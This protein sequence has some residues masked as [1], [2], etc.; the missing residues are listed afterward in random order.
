M[1]F[2]IIPLQKIHWPGIK[3][4]YQQGI[5]TKN[6]TFETE[7]PDWDIWDKKFLKICRFVAYDD[8]A[9]GWATL[10]ATST[11]AVYKGVAEV[12]VYV[13][14]NARGKSVG[15]QLLEKLISESEKNGF[16]TLQAG[17][18]PENVASLKIHENLGFRKVGFR[19]KIARLD[20]IWRDT[21]LLERRSLVVGI[22]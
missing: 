16:W 12:T 4:I 2:K 11:R 18:F 22:D 13:H 20:G 8:K 21:L 3:E 5:A 9:L 6:A 7:C 1:D 15:R 10:S 14:E 19:E 17:I